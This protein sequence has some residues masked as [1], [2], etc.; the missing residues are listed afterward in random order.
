MGGSAVRRQVAALAVLAM[1]AAGCASNDDDPPKAD[2]TPTPAAP[3]EVTLAVY[4][5]E[6]VIE[7]YKRLA[8]TYTVEHSGV[9]VV[10]DDYP[11]HASAMEALRDAN[12]EGTPPDLFLMDYEDL[13]DLSEA[14]AIRRVD[15]LLAERQVDFGDGYTR[16]GLEAFSADAALQCMPID[17]SPMLVYYNPR[18]VELDQIAEPGS[19]PVSQKDGWSMEEFGRAA[20]QPRRPGVRG[21]YVAPDLE[22]VAPFLWSGGGEVVDDTDEPT[23]L[24]LSD[25][26]SADAMERLLEIV[27]DP[28]L[29]FS[30]RALRKRSAL[31]RFKDGRL[32]MILGYR[33]LTPEL[34]AD[35]SLTFDVMPMPRLGSSAT[36]AQMSGLC[37]SKASEHA[38]EAADVLAALISEDDSKVLAAT[39]YVMPSNLDAL[40]SDEFLQ[41]GQRPLHSDT[42]TRELRR[43][44]L[45]PSTTTWDSVSAATT[46]QLHQLW[47]EPV[48]LPLQERLEAIDA[49]SVP[50]FKPLPTPSATPSP[51]SSASSGP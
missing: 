23:T 39:G 44:Q 12:E 37:I 46:A 38:D 4:G 10:V 25:G 51:S 47:Y 21:L 49:A 9:K 36:I 22:Q 40:N 6:P 3:T 24:T 13:A 26:P 28:T 31:Q 20:A 1:V 42:F 41:P 5:P 2:P 8:A 50:L 48:I 43:A 27:R 29:T 15:D 45:L 16:N 32:G 14:D 7:A 35:P 11:S 34:R 30:E 18:L 33:D 17:I 19:N